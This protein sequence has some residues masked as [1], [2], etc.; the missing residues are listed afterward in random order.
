MFVGG[1]ADAAGV[2]LGE[3]VDGA[4]IGEGAELSADGRV[5]EGGHDVHHRFRRLESAD[6]EEGAGVFAGGAAAA[7]GRAKL[8]GRGGGGAGDLD[9]EFFGALDEVFPGEGVGELRGEL[10]VE[11]D[12]VVVVDQDEVFA[13]GEAGPAL[14]DERVFFAAGDD[15][16][17][18]ARGVVGGGG[19]GCIH[20]MGAMVEGYSEQRMRSMVKGSGARTA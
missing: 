15:A 8:D 1:V 12:R 17:V 9:L 19:G 2:E 3:E 4:A 14:E 7:G 13:D 16:H 5:L 10:V 6:I 18:E 11:R 20:K